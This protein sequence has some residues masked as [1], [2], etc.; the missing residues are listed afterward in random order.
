MLKVKDL[1]YLIN[2]REVGYIDVYVHDTDKW[3]VYKEPEFV[4]NNYR[5]Y[6]VKRLAPMV[7]SIDELPFIEMEI[8]KKERND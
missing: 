6:K 4:I 8:V 2:D 1:A 3:Y 5:E 7:D